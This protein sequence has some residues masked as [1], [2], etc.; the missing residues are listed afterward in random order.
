[1]ELGTLESYVGRVKIIKNQ[2][3]LMIN[4]GENSYLYQFATNP[5][6]NLHPIGSFFK[7]K[8]ATS[9]IG[10]PI[11]LG[12]GLNDFTVSGSY[13]GDTS[14]KY[15]IQIDSIKSITG[16]PD[17]FKWSDNDGVS[18]NSENVT[19]TALWQYLNDGISVSFRNTYGH[20][21]NDSWTI[22]TT[23]DSAF[24]SPLIPC[25]IHGIGVYPRPN[26]NRFY[27]SSINDFDEVNALDYYDVDGIIIAALNVNDE[28]YF[29]CRDNIL[30][31]C[32]T[33]NSDNLFVQRSSMVI[34]YGSESPYTI[35]KAANNVVFMLSRNAEG[36]RV[37][38]RISNYEASIISDE[39][40]NEEL[41]SYTEIDD[42]FAE[43]IERNGH[44]FYMLTF[45]TIDKTW[46]FDSGTNSWHQWASTFNNEPPNE[47][48]TRQGRFRGN[49]H[50][51][52]NG[53]N[54]F[55][56]SITG[57]LFI[58]SELSNLDYDQQ[59]WRE[60]TT[61]H[62]SDKNLFLSIN[63]L[64]IDV[65]AGVA[66]QETQKNNPTIMLNISRDGGETWG[67]EMILSIGKTG[68]YKNRC[69]TPPLGTARVFTFKIRSTDPVYNVIIKAVADVEEFE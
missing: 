62:L 44:I 30:V 23:I 48:P 12:T 4:D 32:Y 69:K 26:T 68:K 43:V 3:Q 46:V 2:Y 25:S 6:N 17:T 56:D 54:I 47:L 1:M 13:I 59:I 41:R 51:A 66:K 45:P 20:T 49:C 28:I 5:N 7:I 42:A 29:I 37:V 27:F 14:K 24:Y 22:Q 10:D 19:I 18:W 39:P 16:L 63:W 55:G 40:L 52:V 33:G 38:V 65:Q 31:W 34:N 61:Q 50:I 58:M 57:K 35:K 21:I 36:G 15:R 53:Q 11:F 9:E 8:N 67:N 64:Q 60:R